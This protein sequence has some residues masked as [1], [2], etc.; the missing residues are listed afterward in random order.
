MDIDSPKLVAINL[1]LYLLCMKW[2]FKCTR[3]SIYI[4]KCVTKYVSPIKRSIRSINIFR[5]YSP[6]KNTIYCQQ[7]FLYVLTTQIIRAKLVLEITI[8]KRKS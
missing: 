3:I 6:R 4:Y 5:A 1:N 2:Y 7:L 8:K